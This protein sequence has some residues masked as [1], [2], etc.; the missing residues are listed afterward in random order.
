MHLP[1]ILMHFSMHLIHFQS[2]FIHFPQFEALH[3]QAL[4]IQRLCNSRLSAIS[5][6]AFQGSMQFKRK[7]AE[8]DGLEA[9]RCASFAGSLRSHH[10]WPRFDRIFRG[11]ASLASSAGFAI[12]VCL[13]AFVEASSTYMYLCM[14][15]CIYAFLFIC[16]FSFF[17]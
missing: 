2:I 15:I 3:F 13:F 11:L 12:R 4:C 7:T 16:L 17:F 5:G 14:Y 8:A 1:T 9:C 6:L 10:W